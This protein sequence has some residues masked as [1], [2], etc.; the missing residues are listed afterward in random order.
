MPRR[1][2]S[3]RTGREIADHKRAPPPIDDHSADWR[4]MLEHEAVRALSVRT[5]T[6]AALRLRY[7]PILTDDDQ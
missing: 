4:T 3:R 6:G 7:I 2:R 1:A 5:F